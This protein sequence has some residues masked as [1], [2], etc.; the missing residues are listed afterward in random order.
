KRQRRRETP[1]RR[2]LALKFTPRQVDVSDKGL[3]CGPGGRPA[4]YE[5]HFGLRERPFPPTPDHAFYYP[6][7][8]HERAL[9]RLLQGLT[10]GEGLLLLT[11]PPGTGKTFLCHCLLDRLPTG[12]ST[13]FLTNSHLTDRASLLQAILF[14]L[15]LPYQDRSEQDMRLALTDHLLSTY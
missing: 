1:R 4:M 11:G 6:A 3:P 15:S 8:S 12:I 14:D 10:D 2:P 5:S 7:T 13:A 9:A